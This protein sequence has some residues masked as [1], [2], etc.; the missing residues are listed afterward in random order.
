MTAGARAISLATILG[1]ALV[2]GHTS[3]NAATSSGPIDILHYDVSMSVDFNDRTITGETAIL[4]RVIAPDQRSLSFSGNALNVTGA[5]LGRE[6]L[7]ISRRGSALVIGL[8]GA[9]PSGTT[10]KI[11]LT[12]E[13]KPARGL[14]FGPRSVYSGYFA[15]DWMICPL[16]APGDKATITM[17]LL[18][19]EGMTS[20]GP[21]RLLSRS[22]AG[23]GLERQVWREDRPYSSYLYGFALGDFHQATAKAGSTDLVYLS[24]TATPDRLTTLFAPT[25]DMLLFFQDKAGVPFPHARYVQVHDSGSDAQEAANFSIIG[26]GVIA[27]SLADPQDDWAIAHELAHQWWGNSITCTDWSQFWLNEGVTVFMVAAW[28]EH[29]WGRAAYDK[30]LGLLQ[31]RVDEASRTGVDRPL[32]Y[33]GTYPSLSL[34]RAIQ[35]SKGALFMDRLRRELGDETF[36]RALKI[37]TRVYAG[38]VVE[39]RDLQMSFERT[40]ERNLSELFNAWVY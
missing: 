38:G 25:G 18:V 39:S 22:G 27:P 29:R 19:P 12:Y 10:Q 33:S 2:A 7:S 21:G 32:T 31:T 36:W 24:A 17:T 11:T 14:V 15:C 16:D 26:D 8:P 5:Y 20:L 35:Y 37:Y 23:P 9:L 28:K 4:F 34:R 1:V 3:G 6:T 40:S 30:E 13:G